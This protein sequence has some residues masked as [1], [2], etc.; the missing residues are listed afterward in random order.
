MGGS[1]HSTR[2]KFSRNR[3]EKGK[4][5]I[6][7]ALQTFKIGDK[8]GFKADGGV[9][10]GIYHPR[11]HGKSGVV[12]GTRGRCYEITIKDINKTKTIVVSPSHLVRIE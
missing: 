2:D 7:R 1:R 10:K 12:K 3:S 5:D 4:I 9:Q 8:V 6:T 11:F